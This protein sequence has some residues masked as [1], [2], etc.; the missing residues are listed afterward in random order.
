MRN[1]QRYS[2]G[3]L[4][5]LS[6]QQ[7]GTL[8][9]IILADCINIQQLRLHSFDVLSRSEDSFPEVNSWW[10][11]VLDAVERID[12]HLAQLTSQFQGR[13]DIHTIPESTQTGKLTTLDYYH[14]IQVAK[15]WNQQRSARI[16]L[17]EFLLAIC[18]QVYP[19]HRIR[20]NDN[21]LETL[22]KRS[23]EV[24]ALMASQICASIPFNLR[25]LSADGRGCSS[26][27]QQVAGACALIWPLETIAKCCFTSEHHRLTARVTLAEIGNTIGVRQAT[28]KLSELS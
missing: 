28:R 13:W 23:V 14:D 27:A 11:G 7:P 5:W 12:T 24:I 10:T 18:E 20:D 9:A 6:K 16:I 19:Q 2:P 4:Q 1:H 17:H 22:R 21:Y 26:D 25:R 3:S 15:I 8:A